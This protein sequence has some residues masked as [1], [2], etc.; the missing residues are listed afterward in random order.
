MTWDKQTA[1]LAARAYAVRHS[2]IEDVTTDEAIFDHTIT[3]PPYARRTQ[4]NTRRGDKR[5]DAISKDMP[6]GFDA[7]TYAKRS[8]WAEWIARVTRRWAAVFSDHES[9]MDWAEH[10]ERAGM[11]YVRCAIWVRTGDRDLEQVT[12]KP[13]PSGAPQFTG[14]RPAA[15]HEVI[16]LAH[17]PERRMRWNGGGRQGVYV[18]PIVSP[19]NR[20]HSTEKPLSLMLDIV[21][22]FARPGET[23]VDPFCGSGTTLVAAKQL[24]VACAGIELDQ[25][26]ASLAAR[27][28]AAATTLATR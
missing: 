18:A 5:D 7:A 21:R 22:D 12:G 20:L 15:G 24:G 28:A 11:V 26:H 17:Q 4:D 2:A 27:R 3:D 16:V 13:T 8:R 10:L 25:K 1:E 14:D 19:E 9:S 6:L 23:V